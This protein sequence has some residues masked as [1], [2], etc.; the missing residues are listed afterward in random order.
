MNDI[1]LKRNAAYLSLGIGIFIFLIKILAYYLTHS[2]AIFADAAESVVH[3]FA[4]MM[5]VYSI[6]LSTKPPDKTHLYGHGNIEYFSAGFEGLFIVIAA[7]V[8]IYNSVEHLISGAYLNSL[9]YGSVLIGIAGFTNLFLGFFLI[10]RGEK[11]NSIALIADGKHVLTDSFTSIGIVVG[12]VLVLLTDW[13]ILDPVIAILVA[14][15]IIFTGYKLVRES[16]GG[17]MNE[18]DKKLLKDI[19]ELLVSLRKD[20]WID[21]HQL[22]F[23]QS[24]EKVFIDFHLTL[25]YYFTIR[26]THDEEEEIAAELLTIIPNSQLKIHFDYCNEDLC[27][28]CMYKKCNVRKEEFSKKINWDEEKIIGE[29]INQSSHIS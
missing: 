22:R 23:W 28:V 25:P 20:Y 5:A 1:K 13:Y 7:I 15:N 11:T 16:I 14:F 9:D 17:L 19:V 4:T 21:L 24:A 18:T 29:A 8:I 3:I 26:Q 27:K 2:S 10:K 6:V 12:L